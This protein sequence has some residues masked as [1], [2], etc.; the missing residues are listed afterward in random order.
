MKLSPVSVILSDGDGSPHL[1][2]RADKVVQEIRA[3]YS[4]DE[5]LAAAIREVEKDWGA[6]VDIYILRQEEVDVSEVVYEFYA[7][8]A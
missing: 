6:D 3:H 5:V 1:I 8:S 2:V 4:L 7:E